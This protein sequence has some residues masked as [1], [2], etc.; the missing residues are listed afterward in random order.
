MKQH[1]SKNQI[2]IRVWIILPTLFYLFLIGCYTISLNSPQAFVCTIDFSEYD[3][4]PL[5]DQESDLSI[6]FDPADQ[7]DNIAFLSRE[8][9]L[10][11][12]LDIKAARIF[13]QAQR[14][15]A[16]RKN[17][18][19]NCLKGVRLGLSQVKKSKSKRKLRDNI[20]FHLLNQDV[21][22]TQTY[23]PGRSAKDF[24]TWAQQNPRTLCQELGLADVTHIPV[25]QLLDHGLV[26]LYEEGQ[27]GFHKQFGHVEVIVKQRKGKIACSDHCRP[28]NKQCRPKAVLALVK[29][30][31]FL[32][33][34][35]MH[36]ANNESESSRKDLTIEPT[37]AG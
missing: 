31:R 9:S 2:K 11:Q 35:Q 10:L 3:P 18:R 20:I 1:E 29:D 21:D 26:Y 30:C 17:T 16:I 19:G 14:R 23:N 6:E 13:S 37:N 4:K 7:L 5:D 22:N 27:C 24:L 36:L 32:E 8:E 28:I 15:V 33:Q 25:N 34:E 12:A